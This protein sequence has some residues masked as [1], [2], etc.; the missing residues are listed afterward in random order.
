VRGTCI[1]ALLNGVLLRFPVPAAHTQPLYSATQGWGAERHASLGGFPKAVP[2]STS[3]GVLK[4]L[5]QLAVRPP[6]LCPRH[7]GCCH[8]VN[9]HIGGVALSLPLTL[10]H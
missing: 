10:A 3:T 2:C 1:P 9:S 5:R 7:L 8:P 6:P 4:L